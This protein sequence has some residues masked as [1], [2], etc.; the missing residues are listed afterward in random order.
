MNKRITSVILTILMIFSSVGILQEPYR[1]YAI[2]NQY[3]SYI[4]GLVGTDAK[5][6][7]DASGTQCVEL[8]KFYIERYFGIYTQTLALGN[9][10]NMYKVVAERFP[11]TFA[12]IDYYD[13][14]TPM[15]GD[16]I[17]Y[18]SSSAPTWGHAAVVY[19]V[20]GDTYKIA[21]QWAGSN[22]V[23]SNTKTVNAGQY[24]I[25]Y[26][27]IGVARPLVDISEVDLYISTDKTNYVI[28]EDVKFSFNGEN[29]AELYIPIDVNGVRQDF[30]NVTGKTSYTCQFYTP[31]KYGYYLVGRNSNGDKTAEYKEFEVYDSIPS[32]A[33]I[34]LEKSSYSIGDNVVFSVSGENASEYQLGIYKDG[35]RYATTPRFIENTYYYQVNEPGEYYAYVSCYNAMG[36]DDSSTVSFSVSANEIGESNI[37]IDKIKYAKGEEIVFKVSSD[38]AQEYQVGIFKDDERYYT[39]E[40]FTQNE[41]SYQLTEAGNYYAYVSAYNSSGYKDSRP[42]SF[43]VYEEAPKES[44]ISIGQNTYSINE[45]VDF[46]VMSDMAE[47]YQIGIYRNGERVDTT[48]RFQEN[49]YYYTPTQPGEYSAYVSSYNAFGYKDSEKVSFL[50]FSNIKGDCNNDGEFSL[51][52]VV[53]L[54]K[55][56]IC[57]PNATLTDWQAADLCDDDR[58]DVFDLCIMKRELLKKN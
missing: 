55:W 33:N 3:T 49:D 51:A 27:I 41:F 56:V 45:E 6:W 14:F 17:S 42:V 47:E 11:D 7:G 54:Q 2:T 20:S 24:G 9:G 31:G 23:R 26:S 21:E 53:M 44:A 28:G 13:G 43:I 10:N 1:T 25:S 32:N 52:D 34:T 39:S 18:H 58:I 48:P 22:T 16:I 57:T 15:P 50:V 38:L 46:Y 36:Y 5:E 19:E 8:A 35:E 29:I 4:K 12:S 37:L 40:R 30:I